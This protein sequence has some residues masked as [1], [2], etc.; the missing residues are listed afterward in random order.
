M[1]LRQPRLSRTG[2]ARN[3]PAC[4]LVLHSAAQHCT[5]AQF[6][7]WPAALTSPLLGSQAAAW[8]AVLH[9]S[10]CGLP[11][12]PANAAGLVSPHLWHA[13]LLPTH[14]MSCM[15]LQ[16]SARLPLSLHHNKYTL[17]GAPRRRGGGCSS[18]RG[19]RPA[20]NACKLML[21]PVAL[22][23]AEFVAS[24]RLPELL[25]A[26]GAVSLADA[27]CRATPLPNEAA[28]SRQQAA[29]SLPCTPPPPA[30]RR[31]AWG[32]GEALGGR[33]SSVFAC[34]RCWT[35]SERASPPV[36]PRSWPKSPAAPCLA[37]LGLSLA[38][39]QAGCL[40]NRSPGRTT[41]A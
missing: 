22:P 38:C 37:C 20:G 39:S 26:T 2:V 24:G 5:C 41:H 4:V 25:E 7:C 34:C 27:E 30:R 35:S 36:L 31:G 28:G 40:G 1:R 6:P 15:Q 10:A 8:M 11:P 3:T 16:G 29:A 23:T 32:T 18:S 14:A 13:S 12:L 21:E 19:N 17:A 33:G 9:P